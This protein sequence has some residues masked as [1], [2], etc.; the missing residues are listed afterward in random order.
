M[1]ILK[2][3]L[4]PWNGTYLPQIGPKS[5]DTLFV[6]STL[7]NFLKVCTMIGYYNYTKVAIINISK[8][9][10]SPKWDIFS[11]N[12]AIKLAHQKSTP[13]TFW[14]FG[15]FDGAKV[16]KDDNS[17]HFE[18]TLFCPKMGH[19]YPELGQKTRALKSRNPHYG[20]L[21]SLTWW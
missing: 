4:L 3:I 15:F 9:L 11:P 6:E 17:E 5:P 14:N 1:N 18:N 20:F 16:I 13:R 10:L 2:K 19:F 21:W 8:N 12:W 7:S